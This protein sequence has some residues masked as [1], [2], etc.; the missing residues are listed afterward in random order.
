MCSSVAATV[1]STAGSEDR[2]R[3]PRDVGLGPC[4]PLRVVPRPERQLG[5]DALRGEERVVDDHDLELGAGDRRRRLD[6]VDHRH[7]RH[8][9]GCVEDAR[10]ARRVAARSRKSPRS[11]VS[12]AWKRAGERRRHDHLAAARGAM[13]P[14]GEAARVVVRPDHVSRAGRCRPLAEGLRHA[15]LAERLQ[16][17]VA[18]RRRSPRS[19][20]PRSSRAGR[21]RRAAPRDPRRPRSSRR[22]RSGRPGRAGSSAASPTSRG[23]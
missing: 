6:E 11:R 18:C 14:P 9:P 5:L 16:G 23:R 4:R 21:S 19:S 8:R 15:L 22:R 7:G 12:I 20:R 2:P 17:P 10:R 13:R 1:S 3:A